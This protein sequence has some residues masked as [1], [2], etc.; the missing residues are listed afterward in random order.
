M[1]ATCSL[2]LKLIGAKMQ[3]GMVG[4][5][6]YARVFVHVCVCMHACVRACVCLCVCISSWV[7]S[8]T[9]ASYV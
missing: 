5:C 2:G 3:V 9:K 1:R 6:V 7:Y 8:N 4:V